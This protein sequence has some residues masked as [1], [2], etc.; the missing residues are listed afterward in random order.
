MKVERVEEVASFK[1]LK[2]A[3]QFDKRVDLACNITS[4]NK[5]TFVVMNGRWKSP[6][7]VMRVSLICCFAFV[8]H[9]PRDHEPSTRTTKRKQVRN[10]TMRYTRL[11][12]DGM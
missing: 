7:G 10:A 2:S 3:S 9:A 8:V 1:R 5:Y 12:P 4:D 11:D 6:R